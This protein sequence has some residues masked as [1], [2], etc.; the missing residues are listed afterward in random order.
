[1]EQTMP[2]QAGAADESLYYG[3]GGQDTKLFGKWTYEDLSCE[4]ISLKDYISIT[5]DQKANI[6][7]PHTAQRYQT[8]RFRKALC[9]VVERLVCSMM[10]HGRNNGKKSLA[11]R[12]VKDALEIIHLQTNKNPIQAI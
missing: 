8:K 2:D 10:M 4:D 5:R 3:V 6:Y 7:V 1:M 12:I 9:P 11:I